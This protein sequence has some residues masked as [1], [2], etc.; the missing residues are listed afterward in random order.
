MTPPIGQTRAER[1]MAEGRAAAAADLLLALSRSEQI[2]PVYLL[3]AH[4]EDRRRLEALG[5]VSWDGP[6]ETFHFGRALAAFAQ[7]T[8]AEALAYFGG[9]SAP[10]LQPSLV[11][12]ICTRLQQASG[13]LAIVNNLHSTDWIVLNSADR[14]SSLDSLL[15]TDNPLGWVLSHEGE[16][17]VEAL[18]AC[19]ATRADVDTPVDLLL[20]THHRDLGP[21]VR[22]FLSG[23][24]PHLKQHVE[25]LLDVLA[26]PAKTL[27]VIGRSTS[28]LWQMLERKTQIWV[29]L[30]VEERGMLASGRMIRGA[31]RSLVG[32]ALDSWGPREFVGRLA[33]IS[34]AALWDTR[35][36]LATHGP[37]PS[38]ADRF[39]ADLGWAEDVHD[40]ALRALTEA[41]LQSPIPI[42]TGGHGVV[43]GSALALL[44]SLPE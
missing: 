15:P 44:E 43:S 8:G 26:T 42:L 37:W 10:L 29:R 30:F 25:S 3:S 27:A 11:D 2:G 4:V 18:P 19:G 6:R 21:A 16:F 38:A 36:W 12:E 17:A 1:W 35:V 7:W 22:Q 31:V 14:L 24:P 41:I 33:E 5:A 28:H 20:L 32:D 34:D 23:A 13:R 9:A 39:A 40:P